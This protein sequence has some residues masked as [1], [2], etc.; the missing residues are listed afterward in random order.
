MPMSVERGAAYFLVEQQRKGLTR[1]AQPASSGWW[2]Q[3]GSVL[4]LIHI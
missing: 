4:S 3:T 1:V 2:A